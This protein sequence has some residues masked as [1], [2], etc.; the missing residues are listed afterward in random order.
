MGSP[1][2]RPPGG[3]LMLRPMQKSCTC[4]TKGCGCSVTFDEE[5]DTTTFKWCLTSLFKGDFYDDD[6]F[7]EWTKIESEVTSAPQQLQGQ[8]DVKP[9]PAYR[10]NLCTD[11]E[12]CLE[13]EDITAIANANGAGDLKV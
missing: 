3:P 9:G 8:C 5:R 2:G 12:L 4:D 11:Q 10:G 13:Q 6:E 1:R 7:V